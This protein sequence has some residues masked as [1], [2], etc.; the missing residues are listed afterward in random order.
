MPARP[1]LP[2]RTKEVARLRDA[3]AAAVVGEPRLLLLTGEAGIG[4]TRLA[5]EVVALAE[6][7]GGLVMQARCYTAERSL[8][9]QPFVDA[10]AG[11]VATMRA[12]RLRE[13][14]GA[15]TAAFAGLLPGVDDLF[16]PP[17][18]NARALSWGI[19]PRPAH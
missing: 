15:R 5:T 1:E 4:K 17:P 16:D 12:D 18:P 19:M 9:L 7:T 14:P 10:L 6:T 3:W 13:L 11:P 2:G 8:F